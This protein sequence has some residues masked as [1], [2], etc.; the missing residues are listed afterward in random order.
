MDITKSIIDISKFK[1]IKKLK[2]GG[3][4]IVYS[5]E[6]TQTKQKYAAKVLIS[7]DISNEESKKMIDREIGIMM[8]INNPTLIKIYGF[9]LVDFHNE[10][11]VTIIMELAQNNSLAEMLELVR[12]SQAPIEYSNTTRQIILIGISRGMKYLHDR[13]IIHRDLSSHNILLDDKL[14]P[15]ITDFGMAK[16]FDSG[17][18][19]SQSIF[20]GKPQYKS[21]EIIKCQPYS[22]KTDVYSFAIIMYQVVTDLIPYSEFVNGQMTEYELKNKIVEQNYRPPFNVP[23]K[24]SIKELIERCWSSDEDKRPTFNEIFEKLTDLSRNEE[25]CI[26]E[27]VDIDEVESYIETITGQKDPIEHLIEQV[28]A[29]RKENEMLKRKIARFERNKKEIR[30][31]K[32]IEI[33][34]PSESFSKRYEDLLNTKYKEIN[35][36]EFIITVKINCNLETDNHFEN[37]TDINIVEIGYGVDSIGK[38]SFKGCTSLKQVF[39]SQSVTSIGERAFEGCTSL[40]QITIP[41]SVTYIAPNAFNGCHPSL[42]KDT[43][44]GDGPFVNLDQYKINGVI[45]SRTFKVTKKKTNEVF[46]LTAFYDKSFYDLFDSKTILLASVKISRIGLPC[47]LPIEEYRFPLSPKDK[48]KVKTRSFKDVDLT[49]YLAIQ[50]FMENGNFSELTKEYLSSKGAKH[51]KMNPTIRSKIIFGVACTMKQLHARNVVDF[52]LKSEKVFLDE[53]F[54][55]K[56]GSFYRSRFLSSPFKEYNGLYH[57]PYMAPDLFEISQDQFYCFAQ[58]VCEYAYFLYLMFSIEIKEKK[59]P[60]M[61]GA[62]NESPLKPDSIPDHYWTLIQQCWDQDLSKRPS[63]AEITEILKNDKY[64]IE[65]FGMK[66]NL[67]QL[68]EYQNRIDKY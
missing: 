8:T 54:E 5:V 39:I 4:G 36:S 55:P 20:G 29:T 19:K 35:E 12:L 1:I 49:Q 38:C 62:I 59:N 22:R 14:Y 43:L 31:K 57:V 13:N 28:E 50:R 21:P 10:P 27:D 58:G 24:K 30:I 16:Y 65:E 61:S 9:S 41:P 68:H 63:F 66:T 67:E 56:I 48:E 53:N 17:H 34:Y 15:I 25:S 64:A 11:N 37:D 18:S 42:I 46:A 6:Q 52:D 23:I 47:I 33:E 32:Q 44:N 7:Y 2:V 45:K 51:D 3:Y 60:S 40:K 26:L